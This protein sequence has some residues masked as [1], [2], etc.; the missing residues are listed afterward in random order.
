M[1][2]QLMDELL[3]GWADLVPRDYLDADM[4]LLDPA[5]REGIER[6]LLAV[7]DSV[8]DPRLRGPNLLLFGPVGTGKT[9]AGFAAM[10]RL[11]F[12]GVASR[13]RWAEGRAL[14]RGF[15]YWSAP[16][17]T[18]R[19]RTSEGSTVWPTLLDPQVLFLD[20]VGISKPTDWVLEQLFNLFNARRSDLRPTVATTNFELDDLERYL[21]ESAYSRLVGNAYVV[22]VKGLNRRNRARVPVGDQ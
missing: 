14:R 15:R 19:L 7:T 16:D 5:V 3:R 9:Y 11:W 10:R 17:A 12:E 18:I 4:T 1:T 8:D 2:D 21:G 13:Q 6:W 20:D 22:Q